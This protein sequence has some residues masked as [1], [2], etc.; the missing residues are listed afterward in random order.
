MLAKVGFDLGTNG[1]PGYVVSQ[2]GY[3]TPKLG[4][5]SCSIFNVMEYSSCM[6]LRRAGCLLAEE[7][8]KKSDLFY[9]QDFKLKIWN[10]SQCPILQF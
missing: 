1:I 3:D 6:I 8:I 4:P 10:L 2:L 9:V 7:L 5:N